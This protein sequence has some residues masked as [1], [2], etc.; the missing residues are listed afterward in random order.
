[1]YGAAAGYG[2][3]TLSQ[4]R[5]EITESKRVKGPNKK[6]EAEKGKKVRAQ[7]PSS[8]RERLDAK[9]WLR[10]S[11]EPNAAL[12]AQHTAYVIHCRNGE[13]E[14]TIEKRFSEVRKPAPAP[15]RQLAAAHAGRCSTS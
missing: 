14:W 11:R 4:C 12:G 9:R 15:W 1:M 7:N 8:T 6:G 13:V 5:A 10:T 2:S 3:V